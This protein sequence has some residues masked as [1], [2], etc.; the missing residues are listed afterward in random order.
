VTKKVLFVT[1]GGGH[2]RMVTPVVRALSQYPH[3]RSE[4]LALT[5]G[6]PIFKSEGLPYKGYK[7]FITPQDKEALAFGQKLAAIHHQP[8]SG[9]E[10]EESVAYLGL[11]Y[12]DLAG[13]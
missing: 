5:T 2:A 3:I 10:M 6:G 7:D 1:Y 9:M 11:S 4:S 13:C 12:W 8:D